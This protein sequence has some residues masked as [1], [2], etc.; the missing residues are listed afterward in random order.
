MLDGH[1]MV[2]AMVVAMITVSRWC[3]ISRIRVVG[4]LADPIVNAHEHSTTRARYDLHSIWLMVVAR[5]P[6]LVPIYAMA[7]RHVPYC[8]DLVQFSCMNQQCSAALVHTIWPWFTGPSGLRA[9]VQR[10]R[11]FNQNQ[12]Q[13]PFSRVAA[14]YLWPLIELNRH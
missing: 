2:I 6:L 1:E 3:R 7:T 11:S 10:A 13:A 12:V 8:S 5:L 4:L 9:V 14:W